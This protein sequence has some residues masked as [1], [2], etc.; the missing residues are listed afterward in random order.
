M[1]VRLHKTHNGR[2]VV[3]ICDKEILGKVFNEKKLQLDLASNFY[4][5]EEKN[6][7]E[8]EKILKGVNSIN[9][10]GKK[11]VDFLMKKKFIEEKDIKKIKNVPHIQIVVM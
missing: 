7:S 9:A 11:T 1:I 5:G 10:A 3:A 2:V 8:I 4:R 6:E